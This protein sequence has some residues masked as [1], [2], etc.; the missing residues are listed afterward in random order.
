MDFQKL[1][2]EALKNGIKEIEVY[3]VKENGIEI[4]TYNDEVD[5]NVLSQTDVLAIRGVYNK[6]IVTIYEENNNDEMI[7]KIINKIIENA[8]LI[9]KNEPYFIY[10][11]DKNYETI[12][13]AKNDFDDYNTKDKADLCLKLK[14][15]IFA[16]SDTVKSVS[17]SYSEHDVAVSIIN[18]NGL[19]VSKHN[20]YAFIAVEV[21]CSLNE[22]M[23]TGFDYVYLKNIKDFQIDK[24]ADSAFLDAYESFNAESIKS[25]N[26]KVVLDKS[27]VSSLLS[28]FSNIFSADAVIKNMSF[29]K[30]KLGEKIFGENITII[31]DPMFELATSKDT[32]DD[33]GVKSTEKTLVENGKLITYLH[34]LKTASIMKT[35]STGNGYK[36]SASSSVG[37]SPSNLYLKP[38]KVEFAE[39]LKVVDNGIY[40]NSVQGLHA[41]LNPISG[42]FNLQA[43]GFL[44]EN[45]KKTKPITLFILSGKLQDMLNNVVYLG[46]DFEIKGSVGAPSIT[47]E[48]M[49]ISGK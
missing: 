25:G 16:K 34:N 19:N 20:K 49:A 8:S 36:A 43:S 21:V 31:D 5:T 1:K 18:S 10:G 2:E 23:K 33:E 28:A 37:V 35:K 4:S 42:D 6:Q 12:S 44:I 45:G 14:D 7:P 15:L 13:E 29:L 17:A 9:D 39:M 38:G 47:I 46:N 22:E 30:D 24:L 26:Y 41:G 3:S 40:V 11:G 48:K 32:F 27:V